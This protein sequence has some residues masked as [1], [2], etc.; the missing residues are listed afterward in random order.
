MNAK[1]AKQEPCELLSRKINEH[2]AITMCPYCNNLFDIHA[3]MIYLE[4]KQ[5]NP[6][7]KDVHEY[8]KQVM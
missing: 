8:F 6:P 5:T 7:P 2:A 1:T 3:G 4:G